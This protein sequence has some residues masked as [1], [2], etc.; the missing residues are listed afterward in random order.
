MNKSGVFSDDDD[1]YDVISNPGHDGSLEGSLNADGLGQGSIA[2]RELPAFEDAQDRFETTRWMAE[3]IQAFVRRELP[4]HTSS[5]DNK[6]VRIYVDGVFDSFGVGCVLS[7]VI[8]GS[9][10]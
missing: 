6:K 3:E 4:S 10:Y 2:V 8:G 9:Y 1:D 5:F 7:G